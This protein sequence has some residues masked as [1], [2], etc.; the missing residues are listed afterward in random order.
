M[1]STVYDRA[2]YDLQQLDSSGENLNPSQRQ[3][4]F[5]KTQT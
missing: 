1:K 4:E 2:H 5:T 3:L